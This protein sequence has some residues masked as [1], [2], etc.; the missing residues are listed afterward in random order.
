CAEATTADR[1]KTTTADRS[2]TTT[3]DR[4]KTTTAGRKETT[5]TRAEAKPAIATTRAK[6][7]STAAK[8]GTEAAA[9]TPEPCESRQDGKTG[10]N[11]LG[12]FSRDRVVLL[13]QTDLL[14]VPSE[15]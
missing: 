9:G 4:S 6:T 15:R 11:R 10:Q 2:K 14:L 5:A 3:A 13:P 8:G 7:R 1:S 12:W